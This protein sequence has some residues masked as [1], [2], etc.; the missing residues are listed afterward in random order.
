MRPFVTSPM[1]RPCRAASAAHANIS[2]RIVG[3]PPLK[4]TIE[5]PSAAARQIFCATRSAVSSM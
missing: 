3:S 4:T 5:W 1:A 2:R